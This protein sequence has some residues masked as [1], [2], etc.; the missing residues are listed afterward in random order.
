MGCVY[1]FDVYRHNRIEE[2]E[3]TFTYECVLGRLARLNT[4]MYVC[5]HSIITSI[6][7]K[8]SIRFRP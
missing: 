2:I 4:R 1:V 8:R 3:A 6:R 5:I 7:L